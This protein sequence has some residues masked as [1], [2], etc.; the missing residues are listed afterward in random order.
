MAPSNKQ[1]QTKSQQNTN[2][3]ST[4]AHT[5]SRPSTI[6]PSCLP[7]A[8]WSIVANCCALKTLPL[9][10]S[11]PPT[12]PCRADPLTAPDRIVVF[13]LTDSPLSVAL[14]SLSTMEI[15]SEPS[16]ITA[17]AVAAPAERTCSCA[18]ISPNC[19]CGQPCRSC[20]PAAAA[21]AAASS[22]SSASTSDAIVP[23]AASSSSSAAPTAAAAASSDLSWEE[24]LFRLQF[25]DRCIRRQLLHV[26][27]FLPRAF[28]R[29]LAYFHFRTRGFVLHAGV[30]LGSDYAAYPMGGPEKWHA[31]Y[32]LAHC[33][34]EPATRVHKVCPFENVLLTLSAPLSFVGFVVV[35]FSISVGPV[36][37]LGP[38]DLASTLSAASDPSAQFDNIIRGAHINVKQKK[39]CLYV[40]VFCVE[41]KATH[42]FAEDNLR[43]DEAAFASSP[44]SPASIFAGCSVSVSLIRQWSVAKGRA[45]FALHGSGNAVPGAGQQ[46]QQ[47]KQHNQ[48]QQQQH[49]QQ[50]AQNS[51]ASQNKKQ[52]QQAQQGQQQDANKKQ[53]VQHDGSSAAVAA[54]SS[55]SSSGAP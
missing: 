48:Q 1:Q 38:S 17:V 3:K 51:T 40:R 47:P 42:A 25:S 22:N 36:E 6:L 24:L 33:S 29:Y 21:A 12:T 19:P 5:Q 31:Q 11:P 13:P 39:T 8:A 32:V 50:K 35:R 46:Q 4:Q 55:A 37:Y 2:K 27:R 53:K 9:N 41:P 16:S 10:L 45:T 34:R 44:S 28:P 43:S 15:E 30:K 49:S 14:F 54:S 7:P 18:C 26:S 52:K 23:P 20:F